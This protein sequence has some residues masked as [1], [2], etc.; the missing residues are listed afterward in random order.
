MIHTSFLQTSQSSG[1]KKKKKKLEHIFGIKLLL[2]FS[3]VFFFLLVFLL[4]Y[5]LNEKRV[6]ELQTQKIILEDLVHQYKTSQVGLEN[7]I[8]IFKTDYINRARGVE[9]ILSTMDFDSITKEDLIKITELIQVNRIHLVSDDGVIILTSDEDSLGLNLRT[10]EKALAFHGLIDGTSDEDEVV[11]INVESILE[12]DKR[13]YIGIKSELPGISMIQIDIPVSFYEQATEVFSIERIIQSIPTEYEEAMFAVDAYTGKLVAITKNNEQKL[14]FKEGET[15]EELLERLRSHI[16][17]FRVSINDTKKHLTVIESGDY[18]FGMWTDIS[19]TYKNAINDIQLTAWVLLG[20]LSLIYWI[21]RILAK[22]YF[23]NEIDK[24]NKIAE[25]ILGGDMKVRFFEG[26]SQE[27]MDLSQLLNRWLDSYAHK[28]DRMTN[29]IE[30][31]DS[32]VAIFE[33]LD[34][35]GKVFFFFKYSKSA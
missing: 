8:K 27:I 23:F 18:I 21:V 3:V 11:A 24:I 17:Q 9:F 28:S 1:D 16:G 35:M 26:E 19:S 7:N 10:N 30:K 33:C 15:D 32:K 29:M 25:K 22:R 14:V 12:E 13:V 31:I 2:Q 5:N 4:F 34:T 20:I 6:I